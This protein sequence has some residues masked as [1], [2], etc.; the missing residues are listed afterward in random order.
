M[1]DFSLLKNLFDFVGINSF[2][3]KFI[4]SSLDF[5][6]IQ[7]Y[8]FLSAQSNNFLNSFISLRYGF[9]AESISTHCTTSL[10]SFCTCGILT[11]SGFVICIFL[12]HI[13]QS[14]KD[15]AISILSVQN[16]QSDDPHLK[17]YF[18]SFTFKDQSKSVFFCWDN[19]ISSI[20]CIL[21]FQL[22]SSDIFRVFPTVFK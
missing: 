8:Q 6:I 17:R 18:H 4:Q 11:S 15:R 21:F 2:P 3:I 1:L 5:Q 22:K 14:E 20:F 13:F 19:R 9:T 16:I 7:S 10:S 12:S